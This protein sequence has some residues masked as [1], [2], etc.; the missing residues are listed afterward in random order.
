MLTQITSFTLRAR[1][2]RLCGT[3]QQCFCWQRLRSDA[4][5]GWTLAGVADFNGDG[6]PDYA[7]FN[8]STRQTAIWHLSG[9][10][11]A[12]G[13]FG[14]TIA[15]GYELIGTAVSTKTAARI[16]SYIIPAPDKP[17]SGT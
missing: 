8:A 14:P 17:R 13:L 5:G 2:K 15:S 9:V 3:E 6:N 16:T 7:L 4:S 10:T 11:F 1:T 12:G